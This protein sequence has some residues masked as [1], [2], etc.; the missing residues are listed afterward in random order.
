MKQIVRRTKIGRYW[1]SVYADPIT[2]EV[3]NLGL[4]INRSKR[5]SNDWYKRRPN[6]RTRRVKNEKQLKSLNHFRACL[7]NVYGVLKTIPADHHVLILNDS[8]RAET[9]SKY[10]L[11]L[12]FIQVDQDDHVAWVLTAH[13]KEEALLRYGRTTR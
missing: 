3:W 4:V 1:C 13:Q 6:K 10:V 5:A 11:R 7:K 8:K 12:G 9:L 2:P